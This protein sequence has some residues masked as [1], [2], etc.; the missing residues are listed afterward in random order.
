M[1]MIEEWIILKSTYNGVNT[2]KRL[3]YLYWNQTHLNIVLFSR[4]DNSVDIT[5]SIIQKDEEKNQ[6]S[7]RQ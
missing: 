5:V 3:S 1:I 4:L 2:F 6:K 7:L